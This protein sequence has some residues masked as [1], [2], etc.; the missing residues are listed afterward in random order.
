MDIM[1]E[2]V[3]KYFNKHTY[4]LLERYAQ[5]VPIMEKFNPFLGSC[6]DARLGIIKLCPAQ[7]ASAQDIHGTNAIN[8]ILAHEL[9]HWIDRTKRPF[10]FHP[11][12]AKN[13]STWTEYRHELEVTA[14]FYA[15]KMAAS[16]DIPI[17]NGFVSMIIEGLQSHRMDELSIKRC[18]KVFEKVY[19]DNLQREEAA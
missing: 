1:N 17:D 9:G 15:F 14:T 10:L 16:L 12:M 3:S 19:D 8:A 7:V 5:Y 6:F 4:K 18:M 2:S 13:Y 11:N